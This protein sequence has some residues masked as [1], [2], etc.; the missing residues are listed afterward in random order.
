MLFAGG[1]LS[2]GEVGV[3]VGAQQGSP[4][5]MQGSVLAHIACRASYTITLGLCPKRRECTYTSLLDSDFLGNVA[6]VMLFVPCR[7]RKSN[8]MGCMGKLAVGEEN[9]LMLSG[10]HLEPTLGISSLLSALCHGGSKA[11]GRVIAVLCRQFCSKVTALTSTEPLL[12]CTL[13]ARRS[14]ARGDAL[15]SPHLLA[16]PSGCMS[17]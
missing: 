12:M 17:S 9:F 1:M 2:G 4:C 15:A 13:Y 10:C 6:Q 7:V 5:C 11:E 16:I 14:Q 8:E 3:G